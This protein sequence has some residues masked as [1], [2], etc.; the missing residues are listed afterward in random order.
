MEQQKKHR[1]MIKGMIVLIMVCVGLALW[2]AGTHF[3]WNLVLQEE[4]FKESARK[5]QN[6]NR[7]FYHIYGYRI[8]DEAVDWK[9]KV[10][11][12][13]QEDTDTALSL[14]E[15]NLQEYR[16]G[17]ISDAGMDNMKALFAA[18]AEQNKHYIV[19][20]LYDWN[21]ENR[22]Y[23]PS[24]IDII[25]RHMQQMGPILQQYADEIFTL[26]SLFIGNCGEMNNTQYTDQ[27][28][29]QTLAE[30][31]ASVSSPDTYLAVRT[32]LQWRR[33][34]QTADPEELVE[35]ESVYANRL[36]LFNDGMLGNVYDCGTYG[37]E[38]R[39]D[40]GIY[41]QWSRE[42]ELAFQDALCR[43]VPNGGEAILD[44]EYNDLD[45]ALADFDQMHVTY[46]NE[47]Y[48]PNVIG[49]WRTSVVRSD[50]CFNGTDGLTYIREHLGYRFVIKECHIR[51]NFWEDTLDIEIAIQNVGF[52]PIYKMSEASVVFMPSNGGEKYSVDVEHNL[53]QLSG[54][55]ESDQI[56]TIH[57]TVPLSE[58][59]HMD[60][61]ICLL[62][63][64]KAGGAVIS[65]ANEQETSTIGIKVGHLQQ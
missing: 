19:R 3:H 10:V 55:R 51:Q 20:F 60:Y 61:D 34:A 54:G 43:T 18:L 23:E 31:L 48:D 45:N 65:F 15:I 21:G 4:I 30:T 5:L 47:E 64:D 8:E 50:D 42:E 36:G 37:N 22:Q 16:L 1:T 44:N 32:P 58:L 2:Y 38:S 40:V 26:Q 12:N 24:D 11:E 7:G 33:I 62:L 46:L 59:L 52:A 17:E 53:D 25:V 14:I 29:M 27:D 57:A 13:M 28:S 63:K 56:A 6:P 35:R 9:T 41:K 39:A 49:K